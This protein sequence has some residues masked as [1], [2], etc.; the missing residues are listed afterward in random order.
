M[1]VHPLEAARLGPLL[2][3]AQWAAV[4]ALAARAA[5]AE[6]AGGDPEEAA[7]TARCPLLDA[8]TGAC[9]VYAERPLVCRGYVVVTPPRDCHPE[10][11][12]PREVATP[13]LAVGLIGMA[14]SGLPG[15]GGALQLLPGALLAWR[16]GQE[17]HGR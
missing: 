15:G 16:A 5:D 6:R 2:A 8:T 9:T 4:G 17:D 13:S 3:P 10:L 11:V 14:L 7:A 1:V 12:G